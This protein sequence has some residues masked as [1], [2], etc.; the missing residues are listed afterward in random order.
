MQLDYKLHESSKYP[1]LAHP[2]ILRYITV[3]DV[4]REGGVLFKHLFNELIR[5]VNYIIKTV[6]YK[7]IYI[8]LCEE[9]QCVCFVH[10]SALLLFKKCKILHAISDM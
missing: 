8:I 10:F 2:S 9:H 5:V 6:F 4:W 1:L 3:P 7:K